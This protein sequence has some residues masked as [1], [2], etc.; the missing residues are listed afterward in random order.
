M[1]WQPIGKGGRQTEVN[2]IYSGVS[3]KN[4]RE[5]NMDSLLVTERLIDGRNSLLT[6]ISDGVGSL[7][8]GAYASGRIVRMLSEWFESVT[9]TERIG[10]RL[11]DKALEANIGITHEAAAMGF[12]TAATLSA[13]LFVEESYSVVHIGDSRVYLYCGGSLSQL[14]CD[15]V[16]ESGKLSAYIGAREDIALQYYEGMAEDGVFLICTDGLYKKADPESVSAAMSAISRK[17]VKTAAE[18]LAEQ[19]VAK[20]ESDNITV[21]IIKISK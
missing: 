15:D 19:A 12:K 11:R 8:N 1:C 17:T 18:R 7:K 13:V 14:T 2:Y 5:S 21:A 16:S 9:D 10:L 3:L 6:V 20:G 4:R